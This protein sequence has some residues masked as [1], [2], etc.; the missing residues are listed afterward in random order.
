MKKII[1]VVLIFILGIVLSG[2][3][4]VNQ[5]KL[6]IIVPSGTPSLVVANMMH[7]AKDDYQIVH[8]S[9]PLVAAFT[10]KSHDIIFAPTNL[11]AVMYKN[12]QNYVLAAVVVWG[13][14]FII[15]RKEVGIQNL[16]DLTGQIIHAFGRNQTPDIVLQTILDH[17]QIKDTVQIIYEN[18]VSTLTSK[19]T[20]GTID[21]ALIAEPSLSQ[22]KEIMELNVID[23]QQEWGNIYESNG[24][25]QV[26]VFVKKD[27]LSHSPVKVNQFLNDL[28]DSI[29]WMKNNRAEYATIATS[30]HDSFQL[31]G[32]S[33]IEQAIASTSYEFKYSLDAIDEIINYFS[34]IISLNP[35]LIGG[36]IPNEG[37]FMQK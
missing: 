1:V 33:V 21:V 11:G 17:N 23:L 19:F 32:S 20:L 9:D 10:S 18:D 2:C 24:Y 28:K 31:M 30:T 4:E 6:S 14:N 7:Q 27:T 26:G 3:D 8:G 36:E 34:I 35:N 13:N 15:S 22:L 5:E 29:S 16:S 37:F 12:N 25:P